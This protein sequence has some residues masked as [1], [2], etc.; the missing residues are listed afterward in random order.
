LDSIDKRRLVP[1][2]ENEKDFHRQKNNLSHVV[3]FPRFPNIVIFLSIKKVANF[4]FA[5]QKRSK[6]FI[7][8]SQIH[9]YLFHFIMHMQ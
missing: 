5:L 6:F 7:E 9:H 2:L 3:C 1:G 4:F 8:S